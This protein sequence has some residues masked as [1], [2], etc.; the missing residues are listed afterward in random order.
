MQPHEGQKGLAY[1]AARRGLRL[2]VPRFQR[3][4]HAGH[5]GLRTAGRAEIRGTAVAL[6]V[7]VGLLGLTYLG[8]KRVPTG[9]VPTQDKG[10]LLVNAQLPDSASLQR[11]QAVMRQ[12]ENIVLATPGV[13]HTLGIAGQSFLTNANGSNRPRCS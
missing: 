7:Y 12:M 5:V 3:A 8:F 2:A 1:P 13:Q 10:Y 11:T 4:V 9:F 6:L